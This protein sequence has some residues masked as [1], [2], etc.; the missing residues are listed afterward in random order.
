[1]KN[2]QITKDGK[3]QSWRLLTF[4]RTASGDFW[5]PKVANMDNVFPENYTF[6]MH[7]LIAF[8]IIFSLY[9]KKQSWFHFLRTHEIIIT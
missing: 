3:W 4:K 2:N 1:M 6:P 5:S 9:T 8:S 7:S